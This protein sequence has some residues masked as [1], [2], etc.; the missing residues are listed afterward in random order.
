MRRGA[1]Y[2]CTKGK[3]TMTRFGYTLFC[4]GNNPRN[5]VQQAVMAEEAGFDF[6]V[7][8]DHFHPW[9]TSQ[10]NAGFAWSILGAVAQATSKIQLATMVT[11]P[12][13]RYHP[14]IIAQ[15]A[16]TIGVLSQGRFVLGVGSG[17]RLNEHIIG[18][19]WPSVRV[20]HKMLTEAVEIIQVLWQGGYH[21]YDGVYFQLDDARVFD[22]PEKSIDIFVAAGGDRA[23]V[24]AAHSSCGVCETEPNASIIKTFVEA[25]GDETKTWGQV[26]LSWDKD[27]ATAQQTAYDQFRFTAGGWKVQAELPN[28]INFDAATK[29]VRPKDLTEIIPCGPDPVQHD[30][31]MQKFIKSGVHNLAVAYPGTDHKGFMEF[32]RQ[33]LA[34]EL[35]GRK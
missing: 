29:N 35:V 21:S 16:A 26:I 30:Q 15:A 7:I 4:E 19:G 13:M 27:E 1:Q 34:P 9:L 28:P 33:Q 17:E 25:G 10:S 24:L 8:S 3:Y 18:E 14:A 11:C 2:E 22:L 6:L 20:R 32:W 5:L 31:A 12:I 23:S